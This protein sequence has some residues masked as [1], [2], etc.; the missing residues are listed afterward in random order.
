MISVPTVVSAQHAVA[1]RTRPSEAEAVLARPVTVKL[2]AVRLGAALAAISNSAGVPIQYQYRVIAANDRVVTFHA[3]KLP[4]GAVLDSVLAGTHL[5]VS[6]VVDGVVTITDLAVAAVDSGVITGTV[7]DAKTKRPLRGASV[8]VD[9]TSRAV[10]TGEAGTYRF[11]HVSNGTHKVTVRVVGYVRQTR[12]VTVTNAQETTA[13]FALETTVNTLDQV[14]VTATGEQRVRELGHVVATINA[15]SLVKEAP[16][17][18]LTD[19]LQS[20]VPG[21]QVLT[22]DGGQAGGEV[23]LRL[24]GAFS[25]NLGSEPVVIVDG[26]RYQSNNLVPYGGTMIE[27]PRSR[28]GSLQSPLNNLNPNDIEKIEVV[29]GP[30]ASTLYGPDAAN[31]V[32]VITTKRGT[33]G[34]TRFNWYLR[35]VSND[36]PQTRIDRGYAV[37]SHDSSGAPFTSNC[38]L[39]RQYEYGQCILDSITIAKPIV[40]DDKYS[41][42]AKSRPT[43]QYGANV[44]GGVSQF[45]YFVS[46]NYDSQIGAIKVGPGIQQYLREQLGIHS[47]SDAVRNPNTLQV[48]GTRG[49]LT[50]DVTANTTLNL[51]VGYTQTNHHMAQPG[52]FTDQLAHGVHVPQSDTTDIYQF[53]NTPGFSLRT[54]EESGARFTTALSGNS[55]L[56]PWWSVNGTVGLDLNGTI[57]HVILPAGELSPTDGGDAEDDRR[58]NVE[59]TVT[60][61]TTAA[62]HPGQMSFRSSLGVQYTYSHLDGVTILGTGLAPGST[63][64]GTATRLFTTQLWGETISLG[65]YGEEVV[66]LNDRLFLTG[67][68]RLDGS[69]SFGESYHPRPF[70]KV[71]LSWIASDEPF[72]KGMPGLREWRFRVSHGA[73]SRYPTSLMKFGQNFGYATPV[74]GQNQNVFD[75]QELANPNLRPERSSETEY[76]TD[77]TV[78]SN[79]TLNLT[80]HSRRMNDQLLNFD[81]TAGL[82]PTWVNIGDTK[83]HGFEATMSIPLVNAA[84]LRADLGLSYSYQT[85]KVLSLGALSEQRSSDGSGLVVGYPVGSL[86]AVGGRVVG[87]ADTVGG[88]ADGIIFEREIVIDTIPRFLGVMNP[89]RTYTATPTM[90][91]LSGHVRLSALFDRQT[92]FLRY[93]RRLTECISTASCRGPF[94]ASTPVLDQARFVH[95]Q[96]VDFLEPGDFTRWREFNVTVDIPQR[97]LHID[98]IHL[99][100][101]NATVSLQ[102]R[103]LSLWTKY[104][105]S[106][107]ES[108]NNGFDRVDSNGVPQARAW[109]F[110]F[111][112]TP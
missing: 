15:D 86:F 56:L 35:P 85:N 21:L 98:P 17:T 75:R 1:S 95:A 101:S 59:R 82:P 30:S 53:Y 20:R 88:R 45:R 50:T 41:I 43:W 92:E 44:S 79:V 78:L 107:P 23:S 111:D 3:A 6:S 38:S 90:A 110:R 65:T 67:S 70:P 34:Q 33:P 76:G 9:D 28:L 80:W 27:D 42:L 91:V 55:Q 97:F 52:I 19:L 16:I 51:T 7:I 62:A 61:G 18:N 54:S 106:D 36:V 100:F 105:G 11:P 66:G 46:G 99:H 10:R 26:V 37:W 102:G 39:I 64:I 89:P 2:D 84:A 47:L 31:G 63:S 77:L 5:S 96:L 48:L 83:A 25:P 74:E 24:R 71:G 32:I 57:Q 12:A 69:T 87:V 13:D 14:V 29:K 68:L 73:A 112:V 109:S 22:S 81:N 93:D 108:R 72:L 40:T 103:N 58:N 4:L 94:V 60:L 8:T 104:H 49:N